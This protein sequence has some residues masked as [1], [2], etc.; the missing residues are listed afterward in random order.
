MHDD[1]NLNGATLDGMR[2]LRKPIDLRTLLQLMT[3]G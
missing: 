3:A 2:H 1:A